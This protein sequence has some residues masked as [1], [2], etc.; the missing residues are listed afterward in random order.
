MAYA[1][2][3]NDRNGFAKGESFSDRASPKGQYPANIPP[4]ARAIAAPTAAAALPGHPVQKE[5]QTSK[6]SLRQRFADIADAFEHFQ[7]QRRR[8]AIYPYL[9]AVFRLFKDYEKRGRLGRLVRRAQRFLGIAP[10]PRTEPFAL[11]IRC[12]TDPDF[13]D[14]KTCSKWSRALRFAARFKRR[15]SLKAFMKRRGGINGCADRFAA[16]LGRGSRSK[17]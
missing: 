4:I 7:E 1:S 8:D 16:R 17:A 6:Q 14:D 12:T 13:I 5:C 3:T 11:L 2:M 9:A 15:S 10:N